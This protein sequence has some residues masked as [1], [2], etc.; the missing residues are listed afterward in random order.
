MIKGL[1]NL[2]HKERVRARIVQFEE[3]SGWSSP[4]TNCAERL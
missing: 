3:G 2:T 4:R 1:E